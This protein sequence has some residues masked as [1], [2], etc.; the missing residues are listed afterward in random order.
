MAGNGKTVGNISKISILPRLTQQYPV[1]S[2]WVFS[3]QKYLALFAMQVNVRFFLAVS[4]GGFCINCARVN[5]CW[6]AVTNICIYLTINAILKRSLTIS[7]NMNTVH[8]SKYL[9]VSKYMKN[10]QY[11]IYMQC[12][13]VF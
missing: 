8:L 1:T 13:N 9:D 12:L 7:K 10:T 3:K 5:E 2:V 4:F 11:C 6:N